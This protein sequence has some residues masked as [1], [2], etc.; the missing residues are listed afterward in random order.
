MSNAMHNYV[1]YKESFVRE[2]A[3][4]QLRARVSL[5]SLFKSDL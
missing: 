5:L 3:L 4:V 2:F 1:L